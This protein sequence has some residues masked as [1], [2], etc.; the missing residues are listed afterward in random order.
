MISRSGA[1]T[2]ADKFLPHG[3][4]EE[5]IEELRAQLRSQRRIAKAWLARKALRHRPDEDP[6]FALAVKKR[7]W[8]FAGEGYVDR[9]CKELRGVGRMYIVLANAFDNDTYRKIGKAVRKAEGARI[10][11]R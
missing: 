7:F 2:T 4:D 9:L 1:L 3:L 5:T 6:V 8:S 10:Y 11:S